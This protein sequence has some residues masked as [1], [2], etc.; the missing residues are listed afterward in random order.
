[1]PPSTTS[2]HTTSAAPSPVCGRASI[3]FSILT[4]SAGRSTGPCAGTPVRGQSTGGGAAAVSSSGRPRWCCC[5]CATAR[6]C[7]RRTTRTRSGRR[8]A[9]R[10]R[11]PPGG[12][13][14]RA[15]P[16]GTLLAGEAGSATVGTLADPPVP[17]G[18][19]SPARSATRLL[20]RPVVPAR[21]RR[22][23]QD[24]AEQVLAQLQQIEPQQR[25][26]AADQPQHAG[27]EAGEHDRDL[28]GRAHVEPGGTAL[29]PGG[30][31]QQ[32]GEDQQ[33]GQPETGQPRSG[34]RDAARDEQDGDPL[35]QEDGGRRA[36]ER[37]SRAGRGGRGHEPP[38]GSVRASPAVITL[39]V[40]STPEP[41]RASSGPASASSIPD[42][43]ASVSIGCTLTRSAPKTSTASAPSSSA[44]MARG[45]LFWVTTS[46]AHRP[47]SSASMPPTSLPC[48]QPTTPTSRVKSKDSRTAATVA[49][50]PAGLCAASTRTVGELRTRSNRPGERTAANELRTPSCPIGPVAAP[51]PRKASTAASATAAFSAWWAPNSGRYTSSYSPPSPCSRT[52]CPPTPPRRSST[53]NSVPSR[54]TVA[55]TSTARRTRASSA[56]GGWCARTAMTPASGRPS[57][58]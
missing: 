3:E 10:R 48:T 46:S 56:P 15:A 54:A 53:P 27:E 4:A 1:M 18:G 26:D 29:Q 39:P 50:M 58:S 9:R 8:P 21:R 2:S 36:V 38:W 6:P 22:L 19:V 20:R 24:R 11:A 55:S 44:R 17:P 37:P 14:G 25:E 52:C 45:E 43:S 40:T 49:A 57:G 31:D 33:D 12:V 35:Q 42:S 7:G 41:P 13:D 28:Q 5:W 16:L 30:Q 34:L 47:S 51:A 23:R 32:D